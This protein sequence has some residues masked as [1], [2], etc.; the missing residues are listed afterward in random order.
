MRGEL[1][2]SASSSVQ[3]RE[4]AWN[5]LDRMVCGER[6]PDIP[7]KSE[8][9]TAEHGSEHH[10]QGSEGRS[11]GHG[12]PDDGCLSEESWG[13]SDE[14]CGEEVRADYVEDGGGNRHTQRGYI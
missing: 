7:R 9:C 8:L 6:R 13:A 2:D 10:A 3:N 11:K 4:Q 1:I 14:I 5:F 12:Y